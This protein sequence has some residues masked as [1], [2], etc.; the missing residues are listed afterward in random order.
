MPNRDVVIA[1]AHGAFEK[2]RPGLLPGSRLLLLK[3]GG[4]T[5]RFAL[6]AEVPSGFWS[7]WSNYREQSVFTW[8][9][10]DAE[11][12]D[13]IAQT[14]HIGFGVPDDAGTIDVFAINP[15][16]RDRISPSGGNLLWKVYGVR[17]ATNRYQIPTPDPEP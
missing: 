16:Q 17:D 4:E 5:S 1:K 11:W 10:S 3:R 7:R 2:V 15:D 6:I 8:A 14:S 13:R 9:S 12:L